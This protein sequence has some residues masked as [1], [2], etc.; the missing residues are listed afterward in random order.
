MSQGCSQEGNSGKSSGGGV[1]HQKFEMTQSREASSRGRTRRRGPP[2]CARASKTLRKTFAFIKRLFF[3]NLQFSRS[4]SGNVWSKG[5]CEK[6][7]YVSSTRLLTKRGQTANMEKCLGAYFPGLYSQAF[8]SG[9]AET[10]LQ[11]ADEHLVTGRTRKTAIGKYAICKTR[12]PDLQNALSGPARL[13]QRE[14]DR[15]FSG[16]QT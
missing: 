14:L 7:M 3:S 2:L 10:A 16:K 12:S 9:N 8:K 13:R 15:A 6:V 5:D 1:Q 4:P 11:R